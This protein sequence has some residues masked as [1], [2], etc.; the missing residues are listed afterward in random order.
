MPMTSGDWTIIGYK[1]APRFSMSSQL[2]L[3]NA[4]YKG[5]TFALEL[6]QQA[7]GAGLDPDTEVLIV[8]AGQ[9]YTDRHITEQDVRL[10]RERILREGAIGE[11]VWRQLVCW[12]ALTCAS[13]MQARLN[14]RT[15]LHLQAEQNKR[16]TVLLGT[17]RTTGRNEGGRL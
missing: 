16:A 1:W 5:D 11:Q 15:A 10:R 14:A 13:W 12:Y 4:G 6:T 2:M 9:V 17:P 8:L 7:M 3:Q